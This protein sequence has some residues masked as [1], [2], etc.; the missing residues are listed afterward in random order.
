E[1]AVCIR[2]KNDINSV[3]SEI[4][5]E[6]I[7]HKLTEKF[8]DSKTMLIGVYSMAVKVIRLD[9]PIGSKIQLPDYIRN[10]KFIVGLENADNN[11]CFWACMALADGARIDRYISKAKQLFN[12][13]YTDKT[14]N[15]YKGFDFVNELEK[16]EAFNTKYAINIISYN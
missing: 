1:P 5:A 10:S 15:D 12:K 13:F 9:Y 4:N 16:Y 8:P 14:V 2:N 3:I 11:L 7:I 6:N